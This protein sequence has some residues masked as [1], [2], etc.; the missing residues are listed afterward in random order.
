ML[1]SRPEALHVVGEL[2]ARY[3]SLDAFFARLRAE[4]D[5]ADDAPTV[6]L[7]VVACAPGPMAWS[8]T[9]IPRG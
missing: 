4:A 6:R 1:G 5:A 7:P 3:G 2:T 8:A 9:E